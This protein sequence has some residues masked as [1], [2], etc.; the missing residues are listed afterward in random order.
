MGLPGTI[1]FAAA[2]KLA[3]YGAG[4]ALLSQPNRLR[5]ISAPKTELKMGLPRF[6]LGIS[7]V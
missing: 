3:H 6:E 4:F 1:F 5:V 7:T 2:K